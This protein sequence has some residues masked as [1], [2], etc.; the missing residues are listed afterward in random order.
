M[1]SLGELTSHRQAW[2]V[3]RIELND[4]RARALGDHPTLQGKPV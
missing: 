2:R 1:E 4:I 3:I